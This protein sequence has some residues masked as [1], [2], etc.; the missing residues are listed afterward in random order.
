MRAVYLC[1]FSL[2]CDLPM[3]KGWGVD[4][5][6]RIHYFHWTGSS[7]PTSQYCIIVHFS[8]LFKISFSCTLLFDLLG[9]YFD[10]HVFILDNVFSHFLNSKR[11]TIL[12]TVLNYVARR[13]IAHLFSWFYGN[14]YC[15]LTL[16]P[17]H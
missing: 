15:F 7:K 10:L 16:W 5:D 1:K 6:L 4:S 14:N 11:Y 8:L 3:S 13:F 12:L 17:F 9:D 2:N